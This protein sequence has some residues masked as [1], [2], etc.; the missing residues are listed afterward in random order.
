MRYEV[1]LPFSY[2]YNWAR[3]EVF[4]GDKISDKEIFPEIIKDLLKRKKIKPIE[5]VKE[6]VQEKSLGEKIINF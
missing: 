1:L 5:E 2:R 4:R 6:I 3:K